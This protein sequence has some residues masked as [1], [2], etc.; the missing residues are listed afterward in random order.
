LKLFCQIWQALVYIGTKP[1]TPQCRLQLAGVFPI[2]HDFVLLPNGHLL[3]L[4]TDLR[5]F[6]D[7]PGYPG[8][9]TVM[10]TAVVDLDTNYNPV[11]A[12]DAFDHLDV[13]RHSLLFPDWTHANALVY[14]QDDGNLLIS[15]RHQ[16]WILKLDYQNG[17][18][19]VMSSGS[20]VT[21]EISLSA[22]T[23]LPPGFFA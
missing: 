3:L 6:T 2:D 15:L 5:D 22:Q 8:Q 4:I 1:E 21:R 17:N 10:G 18:G 16:S 11:W 19:S 23:R 20:W 14:S 13:N 7:L 9:T 12:W